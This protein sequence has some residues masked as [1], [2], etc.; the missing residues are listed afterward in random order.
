M[1]FDIE[2][3]KIENFKELLIAYSPN[4]VLKRGY[5]LLRKEGRIIK[6]ASIKVNDVITITTQ[7]IDFEAKIVT[8]NKN[9]KN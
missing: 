1:I 8:I 2:K 4:N 9:G 6:I 3:Q 7:H 5:S